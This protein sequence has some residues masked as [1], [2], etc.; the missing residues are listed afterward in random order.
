MLDTI[1]LAMDIAG[2][3]GGLLMIALLVAYAVDRAKER[4][5]TLTSRRGVEVYERGL[6]DNGQPTWHR[7]R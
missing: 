7:V 3:V 4:W 6:N 1:L 5:M 2:T